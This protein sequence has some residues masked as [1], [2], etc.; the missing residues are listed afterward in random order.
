MTKIS[1]QTKILSWGLDLAKVYKCRNQKQYPGHKES[2][3]IKKRSFKKSS[4][5]IQTADSILFFLKSA[6][7]LLMDTH[8]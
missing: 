7:Y 8:V 3:E 1:L 6:D 2:W 5:L 4:S